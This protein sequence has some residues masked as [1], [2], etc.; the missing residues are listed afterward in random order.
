[1]I[2]IP[3][4]LLELP[5]FLSYVVPGYIF[6]SVYNFVTI[7]KTEISHKLV[8][9]VIAS[10]II[11]SLF[12]LIN[13]I[14][15][16]A[17]GEVVGGEPLYYVGLMAFSFIIAFVLGLIAR[18]KKTRAFLDKIGIEATFSNS[19][20]DDVVQPGSWVV[21][22]MRDTDDVF[23]GYYEYIQDHADKPLIALSAVEVYNKAGD[24]ITSCDGT[25]DRVTIF[26]TND[27]IRVSVIRDDKPADG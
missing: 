14:L 19:I 26:D 22:Y 4:I 21:L 1:M 9:G 27:C 7:R 13:H 10:Y 12:N 2:D 20:W 11:V 15:V 25:E 5:R 16:C 3:S 6:L 24:L 23:Y 17:F 8:S 18:T